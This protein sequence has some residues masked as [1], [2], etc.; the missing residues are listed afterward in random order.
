MHSFEIDSLLTWSGEAVTDPVM[1]I[2]V[3]N[4]SGGPFTC[5]FVHELFIFLCLF[6]SVHLGG[7][8]LPPLFL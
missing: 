1:K 6:I 2:I 4:L 7:A 8:Q 5:L 3:S